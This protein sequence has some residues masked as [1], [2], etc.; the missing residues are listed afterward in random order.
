MTESNTHIQ[1][2]AHQ[3]EDAAEVRIRGTSTSIRTAALMIKPFAYKEETKVTEKGTEMITISEGTYGF[4]DTE[5]V[6]FVL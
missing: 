2:K 6:H 4:S 5:L 1:V 3:K